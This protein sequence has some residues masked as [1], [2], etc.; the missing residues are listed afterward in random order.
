MPVNDRHPDFSSSYDRW[1]RC[2]DAYDGQDAIKARGT[3]YLPRLTKQRWSDY[4]A[5]KERALFFSITGK[6]VSA[7]VGMAMIRTPVIKFP[8]EMSSYFT[9]DQGVQFYELLAKVLAEILLLGRIGLLIDRPEPSADPVIRRYYAENIINWDLDSFGN[10]TMV[11]LQES[12]ASQG[13][14]RFQKTFKTQ[15][16]VLDLRIVEGRKVYTQEV[17]N[18]K[19]ESIG[20][21]IPTNLGTSMDYIPFFVGNPF[22]IS[23]D[24]EKPPMLEIADINISHYRSSADLEHG[25]HFT[26]LPTPVVSGASSQSELYVGSQTAWVLPDP[27]A[28]ASYLE[29]TGQGL[30]SL[31]KALVEKQS[32]LA[33]LSARLLDT[34]KRG[35]EA[36]GTVRLRYAS[37]TASLAMVVRA[38]EAL[39]TKTYATVAQMKALDQTAVSVTLNKELLDTRISTKDVLSLVQSFVDGGISEETLIYNL[40]RGDVIDVNR[41]DADEIAAIR[42]ARVAAINARNRATTNQSGAVHAA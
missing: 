12:V 2:R 13:V 14:D 25:R 37:E 27:N 3:K 29:F 1:V 6:T 15:Y 18:D 8:A 11:V 20:S 35:S 40:R 33:S 5:Y 38:T 34:S 41:S 42:E 4:L 21:V 31:E 16:R 7:L 30:Q 9:E 22:G 23:M 36:E 24:I 17:F 10:P 26:A 19:L 39:L 28:R 32:Q